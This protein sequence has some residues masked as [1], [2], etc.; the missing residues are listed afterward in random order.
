MPIVYSKNPDIVFRKI[1]DEMILVP[2]KRNVRDFESIYTLNEVG[3]RIWELVDGQKRAGQI[4]DILRDE[5]ESVDADIKDD[6]EGY[7]GNLEEMGLI[8]A[9][10]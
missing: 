9:A 5:F 6:V 7:L 3:A 1:A 4:K 2:V 8:T 10:R